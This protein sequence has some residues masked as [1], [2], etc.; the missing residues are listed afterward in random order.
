MACS[1]SL[2]LC[3]LPRPNPLERDPLVGQGGHTV[4]GAHMHA[5]TEVWVAL[6]EPLDECWRSIVHMRGLLVSL[7][8]QSGGCVGVTD[9]AKVRLALRYGF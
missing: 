5:C 6:Q 7:L 2:S 1:L 8:V 9:D 4:V 3:F